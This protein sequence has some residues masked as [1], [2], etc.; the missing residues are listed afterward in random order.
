MGD[1]RR[2]L[3][4][5][6]EV[7]LPVAAPDGR[8]WFQLYVQLDPGRSRELVER[9]Q[10]AGYEALIL[11]VDLPRLGYRERDR[12][13]GW[14]LPP[15]GNFTPAAPATHDPGFIDVQ[16]LI[17]ELSDDDLLRSADAYFAKMGPASEQCHKPFSN[18]GDT[19]PALAAGKLDI[20]LTTLQNLAV[21]SGNGDTDVVAIALIDSSNGADAVVAKEGVAS[22]ADLKGKTVALTLGEVNHM[23]FLTGLRKA[24][25][26]PDDVKITSMSADD[27]GAAFVAGKVDAAVTWEPWITK[28]TKGGGRVIFS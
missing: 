15:L 5:R 4:W 19:L 12:R 11:T 10:A 17:R 23:L 3:D 6:G 25:L 22:M 16:R 24:G 8:R 7:A 9:A 2:C 28:A 26:A 1:R 14:Q 21:L 13:S 27:A 18:P 20:G